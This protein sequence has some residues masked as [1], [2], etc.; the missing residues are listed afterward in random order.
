MVEL[1]DVPD[2]D[3]DEGAAVEDV[4]VTPCRLNRYAISDCPNCDD[5]SV[6]PVAAE[7]DEPSADDVP[8]EVEDVVPLLFSASA[9][10]ARSDARR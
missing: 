1:A 4:L 6:N 5:P 2:V 8:V 7:V 9:V 10:A 3:C